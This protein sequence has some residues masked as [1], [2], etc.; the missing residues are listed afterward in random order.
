MTNITVSPEVLRQKLLMKLGTPD[1]QSLHTN[2]R[3][4]A[5]QD[6]ISAI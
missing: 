1:L 6:K 3:F 4:R 5:L 2:E